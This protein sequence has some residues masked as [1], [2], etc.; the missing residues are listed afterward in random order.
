MHEIQGVMRELYPLVK[1]MN[2]DTSK[3]NI[4]DTITKMEDREFSIYVK[5]L[6]IVRD[7]VKSRL[8]YSLL[9]LKIAYNFSK[10]YKMLKNTE[11]SYKILAKAWKVNKKAA[12][13]F[14]LT[15]IKYFCYR[16][17][18]KT[19]LTPE[20]RKSPETTKFNKYRGLFWNI[21]NLEVLRKRIP[22]I[23]AY[24]Q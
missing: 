7:D 19:F 10:C 5:I 17:G 13:D 21:A 8:D 6:K 11:K 23:E 24:F 20:E 15:Y 18:I 4:N 14:V 12:D 1:M 16:G 22:Y 9:S 2:L 3:L